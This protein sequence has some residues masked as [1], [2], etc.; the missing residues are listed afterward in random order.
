MECIIKIVKLDIFDAKLASLCEQYDLLPHRL[1]VTLA[2]FSLLWAS[3]LDTIALP[4][5]L[6]RG[7]FPQ[8]TAVA[9]R[10]QSLIDVPLHVSG[11][12]AGRLDGP[13]GIA[14]KRDAALTAM[15]SI[16]EDERLGAAL[17]DTKRKAFDLCVPKEE[18]TLCGESALRT[19]TSESFSVKGNAPCGQLC[20]HLC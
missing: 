20:Q 5:I 8:G 14:A 9:H 7:R 6:H 2:A 19:A 15:N 18:L 11:S 10:V 17:G 3:F 1:F 16:I 13:V 12:N 4:E